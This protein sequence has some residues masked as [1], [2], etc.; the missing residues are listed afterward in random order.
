MVNSEL[1][2]HQNNL[3][4]F[5]LK[6]EIQGN[7]R[8]KEPIKLHNNG[9]EISLY[10]E[11][12]IYIIS[13]IKRIS[14]DSP[15]SL[16][17]NITN[18]SHSV[19]IPNESAYSEYIKQFQ[20]IECIGGYHYEISKIFYKESL[21]L[22]WYSGDEIFQNLKIICSTHKKITPPKKKILS[23]SNL[24]SILILSKIIPDADIPY[25][26]YREANHYVQNK[27]YRLA[28]LHFYMIIEYCFAKG[29]FGLKTQV[30]EYINNIDFCFAV[31]QALK[32]LKV[33]NIQKY[34][35]IVSKITTQDRDFTLKNVFSFLYQQRGELAH[36]SKKSAKYIF[37][38]KELHT[39]TIFIGEICMFI[40]GNM[41][42]YCM[43]SKENKKELVNK[44]YEKL[45]KELNIQ[46]E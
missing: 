4:Y 20:Q 23:Q 46:I 22:I 33:H 9:Y 32:I 41:Q 40:C 24:S 35:Y 27:E 26:Y 5:G 34:N 42:V 30:T 11:N 13:I 44:E 10:E 6:T 15:L 8:L 28:Y 36:G 16:R 1:H 3:L 29:K 7:F 21:E 43:S 17:Y 12:K 18:G 31:L 39:I 25:N 19:V 38:D 37:E 45:K 2:S 14:D